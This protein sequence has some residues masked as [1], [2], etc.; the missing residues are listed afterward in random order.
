VP[1]IGAPSA[2]ARGGALVHKAGY[3]L[4]TIGQDETG[5]FL[6]VQLRGLRSDGTVGDCGMVSLNRPDPVSELLKNP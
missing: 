5:F 6:T 4:F 3:H 1:V 2:S